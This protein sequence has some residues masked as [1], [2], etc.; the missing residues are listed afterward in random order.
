MFKSIFTFFIAALGT[1]TL[2]ATTANA[3]VTLYTWEAAGNVEFAFSGQLDTSGFVFLTLSDSATFVRPEV[4]D[5]SAADGT[6]EYMSGVISST[7]GTAGPGGISLFDSVSGDDFGVNRSGQLLLPENYLSGTEFSGSATLNGE[8]LNS[9]GLTVGTVV[10]T[11]T[12]N[13]TITWN[14]GTAPTPVPLPAG[15][16]LAVAGLGALAWVR[17]RKG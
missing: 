14:I 2:P 12:N 15:L 10:F 7:V 8:T 11:T 13:D 3:S 5:F 1:A 4:E 17:R 9:A 16:P 6:F